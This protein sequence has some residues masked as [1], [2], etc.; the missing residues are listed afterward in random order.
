MEAQSRRSQASR[1]GSDGDA[2][3]RCRVDRNAFSSAKR[4][5]MPDLSRMKARRARR[6]CNNGLLA[7]V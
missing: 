5:A 7:A 2:A 4:I 1:D 6:F 3:C